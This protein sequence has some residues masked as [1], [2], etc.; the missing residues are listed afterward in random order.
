MAAFV[1]TITLLP[2][3]LTVF[4]TPGEPERM[5]FVALAPADR[6]LARHRIAVV[7]GTIIVVLAG[8]PLLSRMHFDF[9]PIHLQNPDSEA[10]STYR[11]LINVPELGISSVNIV[12][13]SV[14]EVDRITKRAAGLPEVLGT[15]SILDL[16][17]SDQDRK[18]PVIQRAAAALGPAINPSATRRA[19]SDEETVGAIRE[20]VTDLRRLATAGEGDAT[21]ASRLSGLLDRLA[22]A[23]AAA[24]D[25]ARDALIAPLSLDLD[26]L[27]TMFRPER[28]TVHSVPS[29]LARDWVAPDGRAR[30]QVLPAG[31]PNDTAT[32]RRF[33]AAVLAIAPDVTGTPV[34]LIEAEHTVV[35]AFIEAGI[36]AVF[37]IGV[38]LWITL[39]RFGDVLLTL[40]PLIIA[41]AVTL[42]LMVLTGESLNF[43]NVIAL[44]LLLGVGVAFKIY[45]IM[46]WR[47]GRTNLLQSTLTRAVFFSALTTATAFGSLWLSDQPGMASMGKLMA[48]A[49]LCTLAAAVLFQPALM[50]PPRSDDAQNV[51]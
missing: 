40:V 3:L 12:A 14:A 36:L 15:R 44:P 5:G 25:K 45:Y 9:D 22:N 39:R 46:A 11:E 19:P 33:A 29:E 8:S 17:P 38:L 49:L 18:L 35:R 41:G 28:V 24:R 27:R 13:P 31:D 6:F 4:G 7:A 34:W 42:E 1:A 43:A 37:A 51:A 2:A 16:A 30:I 50:G 21:A 20:A 23:D 47:A 48:L 26:R 32:L 10:V